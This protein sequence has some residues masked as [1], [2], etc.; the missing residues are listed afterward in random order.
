MTVTIGNGKT[1]S[2]WHSSWLGVVPLK[3]CFPTLFK[4]SRRKC[5]TMAQA[6]TGDR[7]ISDLAH[8]NTSKLGSEVL[9]L[10]RL[11]QQQQLTLQEED[12]DQIRWKSGQ[13]NSH[14]AYTLQ[15]LGATTGMFHDLIWGT[16]APAK[17]K[18]FAWLL[19]QNRLWCNDRLQRRGW[20]NDYFYQLCLRNLECSAHLF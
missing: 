7:W 6:I 20:T 11:I 17:L 5:R 9:N 13:Y 19:H 18:L 4:H 10:H 3:F 15:F 2:F 12:R 16:W 1:A 14:S 8:G